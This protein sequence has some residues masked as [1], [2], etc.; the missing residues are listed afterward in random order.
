MPAEKNPVLKV[1]DRELTQ[2]E[3][4]EVLNAFYLKGYERAVR[5]P[6]LSLEEIQRSFQNTLYAFGLKTNH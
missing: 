6:L 1:V 4:E 3:F 5:D 2:D